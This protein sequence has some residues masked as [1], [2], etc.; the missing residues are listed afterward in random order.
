MRTLH[1]LLKLVVSLFLSYSQ[2]T[3]LGTGLKKIS[4]KSKSLITYVQENTNR[5]IRFAYRVRYILVLLSSYVNVKIIN[6]LKKDISFLETLL[7]E[8]ILLKAEQLFDENTLKL[9]SRKKHIYEL[10]CRVQKETFNQKITIRGHKIFSHNC[11]CGSKVFC[12][13]LGAALFLI[14]KTSLRSSKAKNKRVSRPHRNSN[15]EFLAKISEQ[16]L[17]KFLVSRMRVDKDF[18][19]LI[20]SRFLVE[21]KGVK[22]FETFID[23]AFPPSKTSKITPSQKQV[24]LFAQVVDEMNDQIKDLIGQDNY[25]DASLILIPLIKKSFYFKNRFENVPLSFLTSHINLIQILQTIQEIVEAPALKLQIAGRIIDLLSFSYIK[26]IDIKEKELIINQLD[27]KRNRTK[28]LHILSELSHPN[29]DKNYVVFISALH[30]V[31]SDKSTKNLIPSEVGNIFLEIYTWLKI[32]PNYLRYLIDIAQNADLPLRFTEKV[33]VLKTTEKNLQKEQSKIAIDGLKKQTT[34]NFFK[35][36]YANDRR[37]WAKERPTIIG[38]V[39]KAENHHL[40]IKILIEEGNEEELFEFLKEN[41]QIEIHNQY[42]SQLLKLSYDRTNDLYHDWLKDYLDSHFGE[43]SKDFLI[44]N[45]KLIGTINS[46]LR[47]SLE[48]NVRKNFSKRP[49]LKS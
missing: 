8:D 44:K 28:V 32:R 30:F 48:Q 14:R 17:K 49:S 5:I 38:Q 13:H 23:K 15:A 10:E 3:I 6:L 12:E 7:E 39:K 20:Y 11:S 26:F 19:T 18:K 4:G 22:A 45:L 9:K 29:E 40:L 41:G 16:D 33:L 31:C 46:K 25:I 1:A 47:N 37:T 21:I 35:W 34:F 2:S 42:L 27:I 36:L 24:R 43:A